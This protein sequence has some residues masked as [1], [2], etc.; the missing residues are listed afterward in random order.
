MQLEKRRRARPALYCTFTGSLIELVALI[1]STVLVSMRR[2]AEC[3]NITNGP[4]HQA[5]EV[6]PALGG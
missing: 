2:G 1:Y 3:Y 4:E 6:R 5:L